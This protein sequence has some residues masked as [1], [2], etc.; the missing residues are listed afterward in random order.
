MPSDFLEQTLED[1]IFENRYIIHTKGLNPFKRTSF[2]QV[3]LP[4]GKKL[5]ILTYDITEGHI[6]IDL[7]EL[8]KECIN[9]DAILQ[10]YNYFTEVSTC[11]CGNFKT[12]DIHII[13]I[14]RRYDPPPL[15]EKMKLPISVFV[16]DYE[17]NGISFTK[18]Q[19]RYELFSRN[20][21]FSLALWAF[22]EGI[23]S[24]PE[25]QPSVVRLD[26]IYRDHRLSRPISHD[27]IQSHRDKYF[28]KPQIIEIKTNKIEY[29][30]SPNVDDVKRPIQPS[31]SEEF[32]KSIPYDEG[33]IRMDFEDNLEDYEV[34]S[35]YEIE[36][37]SSD[38]DEEYNWH[39]SFYEDQTNLIDPLI[40]SE[41]ND[42]PY[43]R[44]NGKR[45][46]PI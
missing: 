42:E 29:I 41:I 14:G 43:E 40:L 28:S 20:D 38:C 27:I 9:L 46:E 18:M 6:S 33:T 37:E 32:A 12:F 11:I 2:R 1:I 44:K 21:D 24:Y 3:I 35:D 5:D 45:N 7:Y 39:P 8:K 34:E 23:L 26:A 25:G 17:L 36:Y 19:S 10:A 13:M 4:S 22:G 30:M 16:Y 31:W 15:L